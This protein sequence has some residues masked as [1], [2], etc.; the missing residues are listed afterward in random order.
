ML[1]HT[2]VAEKKKNHMITFH[3]SATHVSYASWYTSLLCHKSE[4]WIIKKFLTLKRKI[5]A[6]NQLFPLSFNDLNNRKV[7]L[8][9]NWSRYQH[10]TIIWPGPTW[11]L[12]GTYAQFRTNRLRKTLS[13]EMSIDKHL[14][15]FHTWTVV[16]KCNIGTLLFTNRCL[17]PRVRVKMVTRHARVI[18]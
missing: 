8:W 11:K 13:N 18:I 16:W 1:N 3:D 6:L 10:Y 15:I 17:K 2:V 4:K 7:V 5:N 12:F 9:H 14:K